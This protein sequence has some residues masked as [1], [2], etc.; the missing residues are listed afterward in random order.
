MATI[1]MMHGIAMAATTSIV[2]TNSSSISILLRLFVLELPR[3]SDLVLAYYLQTYENLQEKPKQFT[4][5]Y[6]L[7]PSTPFDLIN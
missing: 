5:N 7:F 1:K 6:A 2:L 4:K 3:P